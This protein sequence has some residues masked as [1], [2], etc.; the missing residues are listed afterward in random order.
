MSGVKPRDFIRKRDKA[1]KDLG[2]ENSKLTASQI[3]LLMHE[4]PGLIK[5]PITIKNNK[6][7]FGNIK[8]KDLI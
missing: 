1:Y 6:I 5:R 4:Y 7:Y 8:V 3:I 2:L